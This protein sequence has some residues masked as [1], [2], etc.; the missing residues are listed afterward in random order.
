M[1]VN[2][3]KIRLISCVALISVFLCSGMIAFAE[4][5][6]I[7]SQQIQTMSEGTTNDDEGGYIYEEDTTTYDENNPDEI[8]EATEVIRVQSKR[9]KYVNLGGK[10]YCFS[11][12]FKNLTHSPKYFNASG[13]GKLKLNLEA[14]WLKS[15][16]ETWASVMKNQKKI[17]VTLMYAKDGTPVS[18]VTGKSKYLS[19]EGRY[20]RKITIN[21]TFSGLSKARKYQIQISKTKDGRNC[22][23]NSTLS[24]P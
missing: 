18:T 4:E 15:T 21:K 22:Q 13:G 17:T 8:V 12:T 3:K 11:G 1:N 19:S 20:S 10:P 9:R 5:I 2:F 23:L 24:W 16:D 7:S 14:R 6:P